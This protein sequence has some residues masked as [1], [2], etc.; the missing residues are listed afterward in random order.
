MADRGA[1]TAAVAV[2]RAHGLR[3]D[4]AVILR[5]QLNVLVH[6]KPAPVVARVAGTIAA[7]RPGTAWQ[8]RE[9]AITAHLARAGAPVVAPSGELPPGPHVHQGRVIS[10]F[11]YAEVVD[12]PAD[13]VAAGEGLKFCHEVLRDFRGSLPVLSGVTEAEALLT[14]LAA[15]ESID[16]ANAHRLLDHILELHSTLGTLR[17]PIRPLHGDA[18]LN[19]VLNTAN[20]PLWNDWEDTCLGPLGWD[21]ACLKLTRDGGERAEAA[22]AAS[23]IDLDPGELALWE[24]ARSLQVAVWRAYLATS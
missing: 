7:V 19:N 12:E 14:T 9:L 4:D 20:G 1:L 8:A 10:F 16:G 3:C 6:L 17:A 18:H 13:P 15:E 22:L 2:A 21:A 24:E 11:E 5:D 23:G